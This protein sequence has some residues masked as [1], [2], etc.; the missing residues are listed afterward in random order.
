MESKTTAIPWYVMG[1][2]RM[3]R[4][5]AFER[6]SLVA[7]QEIREKKQL[8]KTPRFLVWPT[9]WLMI[10]C[11]KLASVNKEVG[12]APLPLRQEDGAGDWDSFVEMINSF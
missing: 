10:P 5:E 7:H 2:V 4:T 3:V 1:V 9:R 11:C 6:Q 12:F 8:R